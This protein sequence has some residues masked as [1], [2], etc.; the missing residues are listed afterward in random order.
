VAQELVKEGASV[1]IG[2]VQEKLGA[3]SVAKL[4]SGSNKK[5]AIFQKCDVTSWESTRALFKA[6]TDAFQT[7]D[8]VY[9]NAGIAGAGFPGP[10]DRDELQAPNISAITVD[11]TA[12]VYT[13]QAALDIMRKKPDPATLPETEHAFRRSWRG[14]IIATSS[15][16]ALCKC[17]QQP[18]FILRTLRQ[19][20]C[21]SHV[22]SYV[23]RQFQANGRI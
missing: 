19:T 1:V 15:Q 14:K 17:P 13:I 11:L 16:S 5:A 6:A 3:E 4:N 2:D 18:R 22:R 20:R 7:V 10:I 23:R 21:P 9:P 12:V 8:I